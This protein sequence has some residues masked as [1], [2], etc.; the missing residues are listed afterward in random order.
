M[1]RVRITRLGAGPLGVQHP[2]DV[3]DV[4]E[5]EARVLIEARAAEHVSPPREKAIIAPRET[6]TLGPKPVPRGRK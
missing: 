2:G 1:A 4:H 5:D 6:A 3:L